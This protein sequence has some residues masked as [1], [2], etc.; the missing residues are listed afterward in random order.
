M[1]MFNQYGLIEFMQQANLVQNEVDLWRIIE[2]SIA[3]H[4]KHNATFV[5]NKA[6]IYFS[7][8]SIEGSIFVS[9]PRYFI[10]FARLGE[11]YSP[12]QIKKAVEDDLPEYLCEVTVSDLTI[13]NIK[14][15]KLQLKDSDVLPKEN[16][17]Y[18]E[19]INRGE[20]VIMIADDDMFMRSLVAKSTNDCSKV[21]QIEK[22]DEVLETYKAYLPDILF[23]D[24]HMPGQNGLDAL[25]K[26]I[27]FDQ[28]AYVIMLSAD[29]NKNNV[30]STNMRGARGFITKPFNREKVIEFINKSP[31]TKKILAV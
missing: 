19:R 11:G 7:E 8:K 29:S 26:I 23:L 10:I 18:I 21:I 15:L 13:S 12:E 1:E 20:N 31:H 3:E 6:Q 16:H 14:T 28:Q 27:E 9:N 22:G 2:V 17:T 25:D 24:I 5:A 30:I 4:S